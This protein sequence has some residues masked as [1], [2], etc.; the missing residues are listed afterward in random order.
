MAILI[1]GVTVVVPVVSL[2]TRFPGGLSAFEQQAPN[3]TYRSDGIVAGISFMVLADAWVFVRTLVGH[4]FVDPSATRSSD[5]A[6][7]DQQAGFLAP[8]DWLNMDITTCNLPDGS[9]FPAVIVW[10]GAT[11][12]TTFAA[13][14]GWSPRTMVR[15]ADDDLEKN[16][17]LV[18]VDRHPEGRG[19]VVA[20]RHRETGR[21]GSRP[22][23]AG[24][25]T[26]GRG[27]RCASEDA[28]DRPGDAQQQGAIGEGR[29]TVRSGRCA[30][31]RHQGC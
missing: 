22:A 1:E 11:R 14:D 23:G 7:V 8:C 31:R 29:R 15:I 13:P 25:A 9:P 18:K 5:V 24:G 6:V 3:A 2:H 19:A 16:Y 21:M 17:E 27:L 12:P 20:Y 10:M 26:T 4:G 30:G 28:R